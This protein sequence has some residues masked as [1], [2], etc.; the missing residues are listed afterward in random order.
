[1]S[2]IA[3][4]CVFGAQLQTAAASFPRPFSCFSFLTSNHRSAWIGI[5]R[6]QKHTVQLT[7]ST[8]VEHAPP[9]SRINTTKL[10]APWS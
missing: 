10:Q 4:L 8:A 9:P 1:M 6:Y 2:E 5:K 7:G 3:Q